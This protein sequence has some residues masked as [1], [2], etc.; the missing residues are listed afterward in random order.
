MFT[1]GDVARRSLTDEEALFKLFGKNAELLI[2]HAWGC[3]PC[4]VEA[5]KAYKP[6]TNS[7]GS[8]QVLH[9]PYTAEKARI[10][11]REMADALSMDLF[12]KKLV[13][14]Q[15][16]VTIGY[17][18]ENLT[19]AARRRKY[20]GEV[21]KDH[22]GRQI[23]K[24]SHGTINLPRHTSST[25]QIMDAASELYDRVVNKELLIRRLNVTA[26]RV[27]PESEAPREDV[28]E[29]L[30]LFTDYAALEA[31]RERENA[32]LEREKRKQAALLKIK[33]KY[34]KNAVLRGMNYEDG[35]TMRDRNG[36]IGGHKA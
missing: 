9:E 18:V 32:A 29:Q 2:D 27:I 19:D 16:V 23:P 17:D 4:T 36:Q 8:G 33:Q 5:V 35:A 21:V 22:Y 6:R 31:E 30:D 24:H 28:P 34:G 1:M 13:T 14:D 3:E 10:V 20:R 7:L 12:A 11:L 25:K 15:I 26:C